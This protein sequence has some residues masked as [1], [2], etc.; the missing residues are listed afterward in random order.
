M[1]QPEEAPGIAKVAAAIALLAAA[2]SAGF[3]AYRVMG[4]HNSTLTPIQYPGAART[5]PPAAES[6]ESAPPTSARKI[7][8]QLP[9]VS[10]PDTAGAT[11]KLSEWKGRPLMV[12]FWATWCDPCRREIPLLKS[13]RRER[14][15]ES[16][17]IVGIAVDFRDAVVQYA[18]SIGIDYPVLIGEKEGLAAIDALGMETVFPFTVFAD[19]EGRILTV[20]SA[21]S[22]A[23]RRRSFWTP[24]RMS[25][26][27]R[28]T[29]LQPGSASRPGSGDW[30]L[31]LRARARRQK[32]ANRH[33]LDR[34]AQI[35]SIS[36][37]ID[38][39]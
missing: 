4:T 38:P 8:E 3:I 29:W 21:S 35:E 14:S 17:E 37:A 23:T 28:R 39:N 12:N 30:R 32:Q 27:V 5:R 36:I 26:R 2:G 7:P 25:I 31:S 9:E 24:S 20:R 1:T 6:D 18:K 22:T 16:L 34:S 19:K 13:L 11:H 33:V 15:G 10:M